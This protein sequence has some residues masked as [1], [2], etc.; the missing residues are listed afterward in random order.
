M[1][2]IP[3]NKLLFFDLETVGIEKDLPTLKKNRPELARLFESRNQESA[4]VGLWSIILDLI[5]FYQM[6]YI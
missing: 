5:H 1:I 3:L 4:A 6:L 2:D